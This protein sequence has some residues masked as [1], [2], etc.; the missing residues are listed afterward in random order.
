[1]ATQDE[2]KQAILAAITTMAGTIE[3]FEAMSGQAVRNHEY[4]RDILDLAEAF[5]WLT[6]PAQDHGGRSDVSV[7]T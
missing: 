4:A 2:A 1:V 7:S 5:A 6:R 3:E